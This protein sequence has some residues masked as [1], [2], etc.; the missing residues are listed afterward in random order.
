[1]IERIAVVTGSNQGLGLDI[2][3]ALLGKFDGIIYLTARIP[4][5]G[6]SAVES[7]KA[8]GFSSDRIKSHQLDINDV[9]SVQDFRNH[10]EIHH[11]G[12]DILINNAAFVCME[13]DQAKDVI[14]TNY[15][16]LK[17]IC[18]AMFGILRPG[19]RVVNI[20]S[21]TGLL[22]NIPNSALRNKFRNSNLSILELDDM[23]YDFLKCVELNEC[24]EKGWPLDP[25]VVSKV[26]LGALTRI[27]QREM[28][29]KIQD[30]AINHNHPCYVDTD[31]G[32]YPLSTIFAATLPPET[33]VTG[34]F[35]WKDC[36]IVDWTLD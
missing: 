4:Y 19:S 9:K 27:Q 13:L 29:R 12:L 7:L 25:Y 10:L 28:S 30:I 24:E 32:P 22:K 21:D 33:N 3:K 2:V 5:S 8:D 31:D 1:M 14:K 26:A 36:T 6:L 34:T 11:G 17:R 23:I 18:D 16:G 35:L 15:F 20:S